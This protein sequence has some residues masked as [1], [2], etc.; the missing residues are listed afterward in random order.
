MFR[1]AVIGLMCLAT[2]PAM[3]D[4]GMW[5]L[6]NF[7]FEAVEKAYG[8]KPDQAF[9]DRARLASVRFSEGGSGS[10]VT[11]TGLV[12]TNHHVASDCIEQL[13][14]PKKNLVELGFLAKTPAEERKCPQ[15]EVDQ[16]QSITDVTQRIQDARKGKSDKDGRK[17]VEAE[18]ARIEAECKPSETRKCQVVDLWH[19]GAYHL[20][21]Y[22][23]YADVRL[24]F[25]P[26]MAIAFFGGDPDTFEFPR[27]D[28]DVSFLRVYE[29]G[30]PVDSQKHFFPFEPKGSRDGD[31]TF[32]TGHPGR[33]SRL[34]TVAEIEAFKDAQL[35]SRLMY[36]SELRGA[37]LEYRHRG[38]E[39]GRH[40][41]GALFGVENS[42]KAFRGEFVSL[43]EPA[44]LISKRKDEAA[45]RK[46]LLDGQAKNPVLAEAALAFDALRGALDRQKGLY[47]RY[48]MLER[49]RG[50]QGA[51]FGYARTLVRASAELGK[52]NDD[53]LPEF[54]ESSLPSLKTGLFSAAPVY[55]EFEQFQ[56]EWSLGKLRE[57]LGP[58][59]PLVKKI[60]GQQSPEQLASRLVKGTKLMD[61]KLRKKLFEGGAAAIGA[62]TDP[63]IEFVRS[64]DGDARALRKQW[65]DEVEAVLEK[66]HERLAKARFVVYG[67]STY[68]DATFT[69]RLSYGRVKGYVDEGVAVTPYTTFGGTFDRHTGADPFRLPRSW[70]DAKPTLDLKTPMNFVTNND[71]IGGNSGS[72]IINRDGKVVGLVF[73][74]NIQSLGGDYYFDESVNRTV[75]VD[76][77]ALLHSVDKVYGASGLF[78]ELGGAV[79]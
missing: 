3:A 57:A 19:G 76:V 59:D 32:V 78:A 47:A 20:Y 39:Q 45:F 35:V 10:F 26:E 54:T 70:L 33:T 21:Q 53:R 68:P 42:L 71:I 56:L 64:F 24:V 22:H 34:W 16:L 27:Y 30:Q 50:L 41:L 9:L 44:L 49:L 25:A 15:T 55:K 14:T 72:P 52:A 17:A 12:M 13:S 1:R 37:L 5:V 79:K 2:T 43:A 46:A 66:N 73:D 11:G 69:L 67:T 60:L 48:V 63:L 65:E 29:N 62:S 58:D 18:T 38:A 36:L 6:T 23:R 40:S 77:R 4:E 8:F 61:P 7:P 74:G 28:L 75:A 31:L 51:L